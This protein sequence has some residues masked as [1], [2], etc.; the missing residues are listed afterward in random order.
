MQTSR[1]GRSGLAVSVVGLGC[2]NLGR[3]GT[4]TAT[5]EGT[6]AVVHAALDAGIRAATEVTGFGL[7]GH[8]DKMGRASSV[9]ARIDAAA[10]PYIAGA[11]EALAA[12]H[13]PGG[14]QRNLDWV[15]PHLAADGVSE[16][17]L[18]LLADAQTSGGLLVV[19]EIPGA[20]VIGETVAAGSLGDGVVV[21]V[22]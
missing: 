6:D 20:P 8:L 18:I 2:N 3:A 17:E 13:V 11:R 15:R 22:S 1:L 5:Q 10:V 16:D 4:V 7:L 12:G 9:A 19:G 21:Q 14:S